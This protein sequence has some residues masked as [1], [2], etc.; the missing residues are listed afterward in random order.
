[1][2]D[3]SFESIK[4]KFIVK[5]FTA[6]VKNFEKVED[7]PISPYYLA[8]SFSTFDPSLSEIISMPLHI[9]LIFNT[10]L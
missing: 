9:C 5:Y 1:M 4:I 10:I 7:F 2:F 3:V 6:L 8:M